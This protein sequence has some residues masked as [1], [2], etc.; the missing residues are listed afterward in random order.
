LVVSVYFIRED[1]EGGLIKIGT[2]TGNPHAR[3]TSRRV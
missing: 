3:K 2:T 1:V